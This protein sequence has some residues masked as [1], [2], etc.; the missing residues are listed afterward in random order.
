MGRTRRAR[1]APR[2]VE[3]GAR[4]GSLVLHGAALAVVILSATLLLV[5]LLPVDHADVGAAVDAPAP[6]LAAGR[7]AE[8]MT[9]DDALL[10]E[11]AAYRVPRRAASLAGLVV[12]VL[13][14][15]LLALGF[16]AGR[17]RRLLGAVE[18]L[19][20]AALQ[21][22]VA[23]TAVVLGTALVRLPIAAWA[24]IVQDGR[25]GFRTRSVPGWVLDH[26]LVVGGRM[27]GVGLAAATVTLL[28]LRRPRDWPA[29][30]TLLVA[31]LGPIA[32]L[33]HPVVAHPLLL[34]TGPLPENEHH[35]AVVAVLERSDRDPPVLLGDASRRTTRRNAV[36]TGL[37]PT[38]R[39][40]LHDTLLDLEPRQ[41]A[42]IAAHELAHLERRDPLRAALAPVPA[43]GLIALLA[44]RCL[45]GRGRPHVR[46]LAA[47]AALILALEAAAT[48]LTA[49]L[50]RTVEHQTDVRSVTLSADPE[51]HLALIRTFV[52][53]GL[54]DP[55]PPRW[56]VLLWGTHPT[57]TDRM[58]AVSGAD[59]RPMR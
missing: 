39:V 13:V 24:G 27:L 49:G 21:V 12:S 36:A 46:S 14:P 44:Q 1:A 34:P 38:E 25:F 9:F 10:A 7:L 22:G 17:P 56:S 51:A 33:L 54:A 59:V 52:V 53:D 26:L 48:P 19:P 47:A 42:A 4:R 11:I 18:R 50:T 29:R 20:G 32:L 57:P 3:R 28:V 16:M 2:R 31:A 45:R 37:G 15:M 58:R 5:G 6:Q 41:V 40:V 23:A 35:L 55:D 8:L 30:V 43:V